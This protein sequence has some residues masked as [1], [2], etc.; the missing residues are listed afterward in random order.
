MS[1]ILLSIRPEYARKIL[2]GKKKYEFRKSTCRKK[3]DKILLYATSPVKKIVGEAE[4][5]EVLT[6]SPEKIWEMTRDGAGIDYETFE[7]Y[8][9]G[10][11]AV[12]YVLGHV[13]RYAREE[14]LMEYGIKRAPQ[15]FVYVDTR[16]QRASVREKI[17]ADMA[18][19]TVTLPRQQLYDEIWRLSVSGV[20]RKYNLNYA[21]LI[22]SCKRANIPYPSS[23]Y[24]TKKTM[25]KDVHGEVI[26]LPP[27]DE[28]NVELFLEEVK[29]EKKAETVQKGKLRKSAEAEMRQLRES[30]IRAKNYKTACEIRQYIEA[31]RQGEVTPEIADWISRAEKKADW[32]DPFVMTEEECLSPKRTE[33]GSV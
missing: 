15:S 11:R 19:R 13:T 33:K 10:R 23:G 8:Y 28:E 5:V 2:D 17:I 30:Y 6:D 26:A 18:A 24:W 12:A 31:A 14:E 21:K 7:Q 9:G 29:T 22:D 20:A 25:G 32:Y 1:T 16:K 3:V 27:S 4:V